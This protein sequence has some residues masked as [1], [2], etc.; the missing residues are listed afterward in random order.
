VLRLGDE[1]NVIRLHRVL[2]SGNL[3]QK[4]CQERSARRGRRGSSRGSAASPP[5]VASHAP[6]ERR[7]VPDG[8]G[9]GPRADVRATIS[10][11]RRA[12]ARPRYGA[13]GGRVGSVDAPS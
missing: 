1:M 11:P 4:T 9:E 7:R 5:R 3:R 12:D 8:R 10:V 13:Q 2:R 6:D